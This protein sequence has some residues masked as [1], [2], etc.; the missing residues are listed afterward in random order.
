MEPTLLDFNQFVHHAAHCGVGINWSRERFW[1]FCYPDG[2]GGSEHNLTHWWFK[3]RAFCSMEDAEDERETQL[4]A[5][6]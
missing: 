3:W 6:R 5:L 2:N 4:D 1:H